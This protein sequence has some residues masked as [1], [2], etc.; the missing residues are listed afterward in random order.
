[1]VDFVLYNVILII[2]SSWL[3]KFYEIDVYKRLITHLYNGAYLIYGFDFTLNDNGLKSC[4][5]ALVYHAAFKSWVGRILWS[6]RC[7]D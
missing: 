2:I 7:Y 1:M 5:G 6:E 3:V 4:N